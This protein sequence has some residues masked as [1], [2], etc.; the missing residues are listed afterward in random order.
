MSFRALVVPSFVAI[1]ANF[2]C[3]KRAEKR[4]VEQTPPNVFGGPN[5]L[6][7]RTPI[8]P[9][10]DFLVSPENYDKKRIILTGIWNRG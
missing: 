8:V 7:S 4:S 5:A 3:S 1:I 9:I 2:G 6:L 10:V